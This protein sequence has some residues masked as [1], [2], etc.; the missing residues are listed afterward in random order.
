MPVD[1]EKAKARKRRWRQNNVE[2]ARAQ[3]KAWKA[4]NPESHRQSSRKWY[5]NNAARATATNKAWQAANPEKYRLSRRVREAR[6]RALKRG[7]ADTY[8]LA[9][10]TAQISKQ[11]GRCFYCQRM[12]ADFHIDHF[13]PLSRGGSN[14]ADNIVVSCPPCNV[15]KG[16]R[17]PDDPEVWKDIDRLVNAD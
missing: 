8:K 5:A 3:R 7:T 1:L 10:V 9:D 17:M 13:I 16:A 12:L 15:I 4:A 14:S 6:R 11:K 2:K